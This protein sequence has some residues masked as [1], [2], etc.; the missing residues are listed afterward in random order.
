M[1]GQEA[2]IAFR[3]DVDAQGNGTAC[4]IQNETDTQR[5]KPFICKR[6][7]GDGLYLPALDSGG[8]PVKSYWAAVISYKL[9]N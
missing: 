1:Y 9:G 4:H 2:I 8:N 5:F 7:L 6:V 3:V